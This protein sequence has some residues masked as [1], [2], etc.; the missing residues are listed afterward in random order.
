MG[1]A[2]ASADERWNIPL[3]ADFDGQPIGLA[4]GRIESSHPHIASLYQLWVEPTYRRLGA[5]QM[6]LEAVISW[7][8]D[9]NVRFL[10]LGVTLGDSPAMRLYGRAGFK[11]AGEPQPFRQG[12]FG[13]PMRL[14]LGSQP[15]R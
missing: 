4:W 8:R 13:Q 11:P 7:A 6:L 2:A 1:K 15:D 3:V 9:R 10:D 14:E 12:L 5:G